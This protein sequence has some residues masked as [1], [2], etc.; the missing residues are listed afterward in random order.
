MNEYKKGT[1]AKGLNLKTLSSTAQ[2][3]VVRE[4]NSM[5]H[6]LEWIILRSEPFRGNKITKL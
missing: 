4:L 3:K 1:K 5:E 6:E 2:K